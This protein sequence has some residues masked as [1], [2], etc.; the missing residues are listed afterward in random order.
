MIDHLNIE[1]TVLHKDS[2]EA[3]RQFRFE[4]ERQEKGNM[5]NKNHIQT[6]DEFYN[7]SYMVLLSG[8]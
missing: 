5:I 7:K 6:W 1:S 8:N 3:K 2:E 4:E